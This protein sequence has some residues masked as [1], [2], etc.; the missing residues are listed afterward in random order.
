MVQW[1]ST[2]EKNRT[3][4]VRIPVGTPSSFFLPSFLPF[5][6]PSLLPVP[7]VTL[8]VTTSW[9]S[10]VTSSSTTLGHRGGTRKGGCRKRTFAGFQ[11]ASHRM[12]LARCLLSACGFPYNW[13]A[14]TCCSL[15]ASDVEVTQARSLPPCCDA[16]T[17]TRTPPTSP[18]VIV[19]CGDT[20]VVHRPLG[21]RCERH[22][23]AP[24]L[25]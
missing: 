12:R 17:G 25:E 2:Y 6:L 7:V 1:L 3:S 15:S 20:P 9:L 19:W 4:R 24:R 10:R 16:C 5:F 18:H 8:V 11:T 13:K 21:D 23:R 22:K 14:P